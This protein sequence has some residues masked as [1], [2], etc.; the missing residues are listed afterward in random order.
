MNE[1]DGSNGYERLFADPVRETMEG[2]AYGT[3]RAITAPDA[4]SLAFGF[5]YPD[6]LP[7]DAVGDAVDTVLE[8]DHE[9]ALQYAGGDYADAIT[10]TVVDRTRARGIDCSPEEVH[11]ANG[12]THALDTVAQTFLDPGDLLAIEAPT[13]MGAIR[14]FRNYD[15]DI[16][17]YGMDAD[18]L[19][20]DAFAADLEAREEAGD[21]L[22][23]LLYTVPDFQNPTGVTLSTE[24]RE[25]LLEL[26]ERYDFLIVE[27]DPYGQLRYEG[28]TPPPLKSLDEDGRVIRVDTFS[29]TIAPGI[30]TGWVVADE[31]IIRQLDRINAGGENV[32]TLGL[33]SR[34]CE[35]VD[36]EATLEELCAGYRERRDRMLETLEDRMPSGTSWSEPEGG[37][38]VWVDFPEGIDAEELLRT[39]ADEGVTYLPGS[40]F[41][42]DDRGDGHARISFSYAAPDEIEEAIAALARA[43][44]AELPAVE[45]S[46]D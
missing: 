12:A 45:A 11:V 1:S 5:P 38:F 46:D 7:N 33:V 21:P 26:A 2:A 35:A 41:F 34:Y 10:E 42:H 20:V 22:P 44:R 39:A 17:G 28:S 9:D 24:R 29:K 14:L 27:D 16:E 40:Y 19:D 25:R 18:G 6:A 30:R 43:T 13:F 4:V 3:W 31:A 23:K 36:F 8:V 37:F 15:P 32:L